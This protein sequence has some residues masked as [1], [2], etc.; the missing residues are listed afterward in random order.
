M[1]AISPLVD[2]P[3]AKYFPWGALAQTMLSAVQPRPSAGFLHATLKLNVCDSCE[4][5]GHA[6]ANEIT[7]ADTEKRV[8]DFI[9]ASP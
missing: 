5:T 2:W 9:N 4:K 7:P 6:S 3:A 1:L 8:F